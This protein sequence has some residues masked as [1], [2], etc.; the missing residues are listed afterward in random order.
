[1]LGLVQQGVG[2][3]HQAVD[4]HGA[5]CRDPLDPAAGGDGLCGDGLGGLPQQRQVVHG[6]QEAGQTGGFSLLCR[7]VQTPA[8][9]QE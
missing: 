7:D 5:V 2:V 1:M 6:V 8:G 4:P 3:L 9:V